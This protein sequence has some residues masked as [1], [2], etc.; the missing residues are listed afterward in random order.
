M[1]FEVYDEKTIDI[2][3]DEKEV[4]LNFEVYSTP[5]EVLF[6]DDGTGTVNDEERILD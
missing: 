6:R 5:Y 4:T 3:D 2:A 1:L